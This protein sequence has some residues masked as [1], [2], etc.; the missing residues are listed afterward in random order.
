LIKHLLTNSAI[1]IVETKYAEYKNQCI[2]LPSKMCPCTTV[3]ILV[4]ELK[5]KIPQ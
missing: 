1:S 2:T 4:K 5:G 3:R